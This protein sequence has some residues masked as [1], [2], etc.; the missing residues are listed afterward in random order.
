[1]WKLDYW[2][3]LLFPARLPRT[4]L[5]NVLDLSKSRVHSAACSQAWSKHQLLGAHHMP[6][7]NSCFYTYNLTRA[8]APGRVS[9]EA[10]IGA[11]KGHKQSLH[12]LL[13]VAQPVA[14]M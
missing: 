2:Q 10:S 6:Y 8:S 13:A 9:K 1:M 11:R 7:K 5:A 3:R 4:G 12:T 14:S